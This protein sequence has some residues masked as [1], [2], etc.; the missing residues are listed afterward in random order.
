M[1]KDKKN[2]R[3]TKKKA[4]VRQNCFIRKNNMNKKNVKC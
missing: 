4:E 1:K 3:K 2:N